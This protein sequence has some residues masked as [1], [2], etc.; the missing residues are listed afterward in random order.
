MTQKEKI[1]RNLGLTFD[2]LRQVAKDALILDKIP[3]GSTL[4]FVEKDFAKIE[5]PRKRK[6]RS[7]TKYL[8][9]KSR[10]EII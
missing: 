2:F 1:N 8:R 10:L 7:R 3:T 5:K 9:V 4:E 6:T